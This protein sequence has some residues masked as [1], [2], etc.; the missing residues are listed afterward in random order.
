MAY[1]IGGL[2][3]VAVFLALT[4]LPLF[5]LGKIGSQV[6]GRSFR[7]IAPGLALV[8]IA[9]WSFASY[10]QFRNEC[11]KHGDIEGFGRLS[12]R[13]NGFEVRGY[14]EPF[15]HYGFS[16]D[17]A[18]ARGTV[19]FVDVDRGRYCRTPDTSLYSSRC[20]ALGSAK[21]SLV[22][23]ALPPQIPHWWVP[24][25][26]RREFVVR[27]AGT[28]RVLARASDVL[29]GGGLTSMYLRLL[30]GDQDYQY[31]SCGYASKDIGPYRPSRAGRPRIGQYEAA[32]LR[33]LVKAFP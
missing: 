11:R 10:E 6:L 12:E 28:Q 33:L 32:D 7:W 23:E 8:L 4:V 25:L 5:I 31:L 21:S 18:L 15:F 3:I 26:Q 9:A 24:P 2:L 20:E 30:G 17:K 14:R 16:W 19:E 13:P 22:I 27:E 1:G 29:F